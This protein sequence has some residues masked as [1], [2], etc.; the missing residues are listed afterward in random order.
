MRGLGRMMRSAPRHGAG[1]GF[2]H[3]GIPGGG[4][5]RRG[6]MG[7]LLLVIEILRVG[8]DRIP[9]ATLS[10]LSGMVFVFLNPVNWHMH[11]PGQA[12]LSAT[13]I[14]H[15]PAHNAYRG[16]T[17][18]FYHASDFHL[19][20]N[21]VSLIHKGMQLEPRL[22]MQLYVGV[23][24]AIVVIESLIYVFVVE[25]LMMVFGR[26]APMVGSDCSL[27]FSG[28]L[29]GMK[30]V[31]QATNPN[32][33][34]VSSFFGLFTVPNKYAHWVYQ[35]ESS[36]DTSTLDSEWDQLDVLRRGRTQ[37][38]Q[39]QQTRTPV[40]SSTREHMD[41]P[42]AEPLVSQ[43]TSTT[44]S[45]EPTYGEVASDTSMPHSGLLT[46]QELRARRVARFDKS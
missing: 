18:A 9:P 7:L 42:H 22:G 27:G 15:N 35:G 2:R 16:V 32:P 13:R 25:T 41:Q 14:L 30:V 39:S 17:H 36:Q 10:L 33:N 24:G 23:L 26:H 1:G 5:G 45:L 3:R 29:F 38:A 43:V 46:Q 20:Y 11:S 12:C 40:R 6:N 44:A 21:M 28:V 4:G 34:T 31:L 19:Y 37:L 8:W